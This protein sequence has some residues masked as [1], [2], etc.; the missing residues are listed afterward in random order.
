MT[1]ELVIREITINEAEAIQ[2]HGWLVS[3]SLCRIKS[4]QLKYLYIV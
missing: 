3:R 1:E 4:N 2:I